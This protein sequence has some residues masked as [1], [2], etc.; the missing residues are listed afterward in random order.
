MLD[1]KWKEMKLGLNWEDQGWTMLNKIGYTQVKGKK[2]NKY[3]Y[4]G[5][6]WYKAKIFIPKTVEDYDTFTLS[7]GS[8]DDF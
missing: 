7:I 5:I 8:I 6:A 3:Q 1:D 4:D 2:T